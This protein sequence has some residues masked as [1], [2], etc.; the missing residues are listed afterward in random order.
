MRRLL[1]VPLAAVL[2]ASASYP[3][4]AEVI[5]QGTTSSSGD[6]YSQGMGATSGAWSGEIYSQGMMMSNGVIYSQGMDIS[7]PISTP[8]TALSDLTGPYAT[9]AVTAVDPY[10]ANVTFTS[11]MTDA[12]TYLMG[13][14]GSADLNVN[15]AYTLGSVTA[16]GPFDAPV[17]LN[18]NPGQVGGF[19]QFDLSLNFFDGYT[20][21]SD[22]ISF[23]ITNTTGL[24]TSDSAVLTPNNDGFNAAIH[25]FAC[26]DPCTIG[27]GALVTGFAANG[28]SPPPAS[29]P[30]PVSLVLLGMALLGFSVVRRRSNRFAWLLRE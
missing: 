27:E 14:G 29:V 7:E 4:H 10:T 3:A 12:I 25:A 28:P 19:G 11:L 2:A 5:S 6:T 20:H 26:N 18:N 13:D 16:S 23:Q 9:V 21:T 15:G 22:S 17:F 8:N 24:W 1:F 30:E